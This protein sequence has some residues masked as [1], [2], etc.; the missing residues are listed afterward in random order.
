[1]LHFVRNDNNECFHNVPPIGGAAFSLEL[2]LR[3]PGRIEAISSDD[4]K[5]ADSRHE[6]AMQ[7]DCVP[8][9]SLRTSVALAMTIGRAVISVKSLATN[10]I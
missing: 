4:R 2:S 9:T 5:T 8:S 3:D 6:K 10:L 7:G 1:M